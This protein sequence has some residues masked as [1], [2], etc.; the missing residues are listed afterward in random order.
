MLKVPKVLNVES[1]SKSFLQC[2]NEKRK[3]GMIAN[4]CIKN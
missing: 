2:A 1:G 4:Q 3:S